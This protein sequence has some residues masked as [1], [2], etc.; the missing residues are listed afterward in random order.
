MKDLYE[1]DLDVRYI[2][3]LFF[4]FKY[5]LLLIVTTS[6]LIGAIYH[7]FEI[8]NDQFKTLFR[9]QLNKDSNTLI[10]NLVLIINIYEKNT[11]V[12]SL[13]ADTNLDSIYPYLSK[14]NNNL[15]YNNYN[16]SFDE[17]SINISKLKK[18]L[19][20]L[21]FLL[22]RKVLSLKGGSSDDF[23]AFD[24]TYSLPSNNKNIINEIENSI[25]KLFLNANELYINNL[26]ENFN[27]A[28][29]LSKKIDT[30]NEK[31]SN[32]LS[33][34]NIIDEII[35]IVNK[36]NIKDDLKPQTFDIFL[37]TLLLEYFVNAIQD[38]KFGDNRDLKKSNQI[39][40]QEFYKNESEKIFNTRNFLTI[41]ETIEIE[42]EKHNRINLFLYYF[43]F[44]AVGLIFFIF[45]TYLYLSYNRINFKN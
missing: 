34:E 5:L 14:Y 18:E 7:Y 42:T 20:Y 25:I 40:I 38:D 19:S 9:V 8:K 10:N 4:H 6:L 33:T 26:K 2:V 21:N 32:T 35:S 12:S 23:I 39:K 44:L 16:F 41:N 30:L 11:N 31:T 45:S 27:N 22:P 3:N 28:F 15:F 24:V 13:S 17:N 1:N 29:K 43:A 37:Q 36:S